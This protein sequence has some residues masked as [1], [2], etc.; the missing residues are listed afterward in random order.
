MTIIFLNI[1]ET[2]EMNNGKLDNRKTSVYKWQ[3]NM[4]SKK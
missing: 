3:F 1:V 4:E 2:K